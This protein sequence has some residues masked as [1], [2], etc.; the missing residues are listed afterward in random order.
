MEIMIL[1]HWINEKVFF[2]FE[3]MKYVVI[4]APLHELEKKVNRTELG[5][6][7]SYFQKGKI[8][9]RDLLR[10]FDIFDLLRSGC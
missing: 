8:K 9:F 2:G 1:L 5:D 4:F 10:F 3:R 6:Y 7:A